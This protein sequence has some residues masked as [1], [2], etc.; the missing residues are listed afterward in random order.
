MT[1]L[2]T[3][4]LLFSVILLPWY[5]ITVMKYIFKIINY[6]HTN[7]GFFEIIEE[8]GI[9]KWFI[10]FLF[11]LMIGVIGLLI[12]LLIIGLHEFSIFILS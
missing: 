11:L 7:D 5:T 9:F 4:A 8:E 2:L 1:Y 3:V 12:V 10:G 6:D